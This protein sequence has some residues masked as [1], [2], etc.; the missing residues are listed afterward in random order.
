MAVLI[1]RIVTGTH[2]SGKSAGTFLK[3]GPFRNK[4]ALV[5]AMAYGSASYTGPRANAGIR[6]TVQG[7]DGEQVSTDSFEGESSNLD[8]TVAISTMFVL[9]PGDSRI[10][11]A[12]VLPLGAGGEAKNRDTKV[13][14]HVIALDTNAGGVALPHP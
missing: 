12:S 5:L 14:L 2:P 3:V 7:G 6:I 9:K 13:K 4:T 8:F 1:D 10:V 11:P